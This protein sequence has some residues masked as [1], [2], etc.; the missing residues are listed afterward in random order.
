MALLPGLLIVTVVNKLMFFTYSEVD[1]DVGIY[2]P[3]LQS[4]G[5]ST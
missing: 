4:Q 2:L 1:V 3:S 5:L